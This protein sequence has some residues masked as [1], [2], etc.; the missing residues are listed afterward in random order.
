MLKTIFMA[1]EQMVQFNQH[2]D[3]KPVGRFSLLIQ[4]C[5]N[6]ESKSEFS[7]HE[8]RNAYPA[9]GIVAIWGGLYPAVQGCLMENIPIYSVFL[10]WCSHLRDKRYI[11]AF[12][13]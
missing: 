5:L 11:R 6:P 13:V 4:T 7:S 8:D 10:E 9:T 3:I 12:S 1:N 2:N